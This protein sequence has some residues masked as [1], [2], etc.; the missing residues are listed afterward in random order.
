MPPNS[1][2]ISESLAVR[3]M[4]L[5]PEGAVAALSA[6]MAAEQQSGGHMDEL[7]MLA[8]HLHVI[9]RLRERAAADPERTRGLY[10]KYIVQRSDG[11]TA[12]GHKHGHCHHFV[13][14]V[15]HDPLAA[16]CLKLY[17][18]LCETSY[19]QLARDLRKLTGAMP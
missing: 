17:A 5:L 6:D 2:T 15:D 16:P 4:A 12:E 11:A 10:D 14:D 8:S 7:A 3:L 18:D 13:L 9:R 19:P 1:I